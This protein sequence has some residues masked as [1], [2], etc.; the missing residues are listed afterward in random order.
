M[1]IMASLPSLVVPQAI[2]HHH[3]LEE[4]QLVVVQG[5][6]PLKAR[7]GVA[8]IGHFGNDN[9]RSVFTDEMARICGAGD[10]P[11]KTEGELIFL[12]SPGP[13]S[14]RLGILVEGEEL[15][16]CHLDDGVGVDVGR[17]WLFSCIYILVEDATSFGL[18]NAG[19]AE[20][21]VS[22]PILTMRYTAYD[23]GRKA[24]D[25]AYDKKHK[26][27]YNVQQRKLKRSNPRRAT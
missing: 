2:G 10:A 17:R 20:R 21:W 24:T 12:A 7:S 4:L 27:R 19:S 5:V 15:K 8:P 9:V 1:D 22:D 14:N 16:G 23:K 25:V 18:D 3:P 11:T 26:N 13:Q 6:F